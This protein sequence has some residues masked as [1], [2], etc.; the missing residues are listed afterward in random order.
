VVVALGE[1]VAGVPEVVVEVPVVVWAS[2]IALLSA[3]ESTQNRF[4]AAPYRSYGCLLLDGRVER[5]VH[6][7]R[8]LLLRQPANHL[9][10]D[11]E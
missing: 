9:L 10:K 1:A 3:M 4:I 11:Q 6:R 2:A 5:D 7:H 8:E